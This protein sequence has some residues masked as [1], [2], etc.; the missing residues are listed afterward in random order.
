MALDQE[1][2]LDRR[3]LQRRL[4]LWRLVAVAAVAV[5]VLAG[6]ARFLPWER[7][8]IARL[9]VDDIIVD[10][11]ERTEAVERVA[12]DDDA[13]ALIVRVD[14]PGGTLS[15]SEALYLALRRVAERKPVV[16]VI[17][18]V[19]ASGGYMTALA[20]DHILARESSLTGS[21]GVILQTMEVTRL[22]DRLGIRPIAIKSDPMKGQPS[23][24]EPLS[25][26][27]REVVEATVRDS[28]RQFVEIVAER[29]GLSEAALGTVTDGRIFTGR[30]ALAQRLIDAIGGEREAVAWLGEARGIDPD[31]PVVDLAWGE[32][33]D[34]LY[35]LTGALFGKAYSFERLT[36]DGLVAL[37]HPRLQ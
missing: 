35:E 9:W 10:D 25:E 6:I 26:P 28:H 1:A 16:A 13:V 29:R 12:E 11:L 15:G 8:H 36:L 24:L 2:L 18:N 17:G 33:T 22:L 37:W 27:A 14:S 23:P 19:G 7:T 20:A 5:A 32:P 21:I 31:L 3:R 34:L 4:T 30:Q